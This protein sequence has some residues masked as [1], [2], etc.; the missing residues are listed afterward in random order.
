MLNYYYHTRTCVCFFCFYL[1]MMENH[2]KLPDDVNKQDSISES[3]QQEKKSLVETLNS[4]QE[5]NS[6][7]L[8]YN[9]FSK[10]WKRENWMFKVNKDLINIDEYWEKYIVLDWERYYESGIHP[11]RFMMMEDHFW[12]PHFYV[13]EVDE[14]W[15]R[16]GN[17]LIIMCDGSIFKWEWDKKWELK[18]ENWTYTW[19]FEECRPVDKHTKPSFL[20]KGEYVY[21]DKSSETYVAFPQSIWMVKFINSKDMKRSED[22]SRERGSMVGVERVSPEGDVSYGFHS[23]HRDCEY[24]ATEDNYVFEAAPWCVITL[25][26]YQEKDIDTFRYTPKEIEEWH[27]RSSATRKCRDRARYFAH[28][29]NAIGNFIKEHKSVRFS[30][31]WSDLKVKYW[32]KFLKVTLIRDIPAKVEVSAK[33]FADWLNIYYWKYVFGNRKKTA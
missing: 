2:N 16:V 6:D 23:W 32:E 18:T 17:G 5:I 31:S 9:N 30:A 14:D 10:V 12:M 3:L 25:P 7:E 33:D 24:T 28:L 1:F 8:W 13:W 27:W 20:R 21:N 11:N 4:S 15:Y 26:K 29:V 19:N 22:R